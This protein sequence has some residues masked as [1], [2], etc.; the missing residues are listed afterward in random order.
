MTQRPHDALFKLAFDQPD[1][2][3]DLCRGLLAPELAAAIAWDTAPRTPGSFIDPALADFHSDL[4]FTVN[5]AGHPTYLYVLVE[6]QSTR[7]E[8][9]PLRMLNYAVRVWM[10]H[11][12][13]HGAP[14]P[15]L[16]SVLVSHAPG[17]WRG[18]RTLHELIVPNPASLPGLSELVPNMGFILDDLTLCSDEQLRERALAAFSKLTLWLLRSG[19]DGPTLLTQLESWVPILEQLLQAPTQAEALAHL[20]RYVALVSDEMNFDEFRGKL[21]QALPT[22]EDTLMTIA[23]ELH[24]KGLIQGREQGLEQGRAQTLIKLVQLKFG[25]ASAA[26]IPQIQ[27]ASPARLETLIERLLE[28]ESLDQLF[29]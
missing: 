16:L 15:P 18:A 7:D 11:A 1:Q 6:H 22:S 19:R 27:A 10:P 17:G 24:Q 3:A 5:L 23:E 14:L 21:Q 26:Y 4:L 25:T 9:M 12:S 2:L 20:L 29:A 13:E 28:V 8:L